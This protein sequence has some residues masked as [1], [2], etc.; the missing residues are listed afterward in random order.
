MKKPIILSIC[1]LLGVVAGYFV[2]PIAAMP[3][4]QAFDPAMFTG[5]MIAGYRAQVIC[6]CNS[7][8]AAEGVKDLSEY[9]S[10]LKK[11]RPTNPRSIFLGREMGLAYVR[12]SMLEK[13]LAQQSQSDDDIKSGQTELAALGWKDVSESHLTYL[14]TQLD[15][16]YQSTKQKSDKNSTTVAKA[17]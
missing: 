9:I 16:E 8:P 2:A 4:V 12:R 14:V 6:E 10:V 13:K 5:A 17:Q 7:R 1:A 11:Y 3:V 15:A